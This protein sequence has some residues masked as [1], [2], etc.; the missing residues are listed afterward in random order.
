MFPLGDY[1]IKLVGVLFAAQNIEFC[2]SLLV[3]QNHTAVAQ[4]RMEVVCAK[5][6]S[7]NGAQIMLYNQ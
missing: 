6:Y 7:N 2:T 5:L 3:A 1:T 4:T